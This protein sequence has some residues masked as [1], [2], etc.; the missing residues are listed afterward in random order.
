MKHTILISLFK[1]AVTVTIAFLLMTL[2][3]EFWPQEVSEFAPYAQRA[4]AAFSITDELANI[5][6][7]G[8]Y[9]LLLIMLALLFS[10]GFTTC[11][12]LFSMRFRQPK[13]IGPSMKSGFYILSSI[14]TIFI[15]YLVLEFFSRLGIDLQMYGDDTGK[16]QYYLI[17]ALVLGVGDGFL[18]E[19]IQH[20]EEEVDAIRRENYVRMAKAI[21]A[22]MWLHIRNDFIVRS[23]RVILSRMTALISGTVIIEFVFGIPGLGAFAFK[24]AERGYKERLMLILLCI[25]AVV[26]F[27]NLMYR[28][29]V[30]VLDPRLRQE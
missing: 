28:V 14:P 27:L 21:G 16:L 10:I 4:R 7:Y 1:F 13:F 8:R 2:L 12:L 19:F 20:A 29:M 11:S 23:S 22:K 25:V 5:L 6:R 18:N 26:S 30:T 17:P 24:A 9:S 3:L 15:G